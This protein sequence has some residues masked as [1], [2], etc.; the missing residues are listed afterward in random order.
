[1]M[2]RENSKELLPIIQAYS[3]GKT[4]QMKTQD[5]IWVDC[6]ELSFDGDPAIYRIKQEK[7]YRPYKDCEEMIADF[8]KRFNIAVPSHELP[9]IWVKSMYTEK[10]LLI[11]IFDYDD[12]EV[13]DG[14]NWVDFGDLF[15]TYTYLDGSICG[16]EENGNN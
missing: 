9:L 10:K 5:D 6:G 12:N 3:E 7:E 14:S 13:F 16:M 11:S 15:L 1:M 2:T 8:K 4:I